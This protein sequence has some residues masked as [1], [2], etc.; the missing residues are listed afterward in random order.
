MV[1]GKVR[2]KNRKANVTGCSCSEVVCPV[3]DMA[4]ILRLSGTTGL[5]PRE[6]GP[7]GSSN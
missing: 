6:C 5:N 7:M 1:P 2:R 4:E 3:V